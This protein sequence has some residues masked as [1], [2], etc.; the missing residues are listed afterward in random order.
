MP[1]FV[2][3]HLTGPHAGKEACPVCI[4]GQRP[5]LALFLHGRDLLAMRD[6]VRRL[7]RVLREVPPRSVIGYLVLVIDRETPVDVA[8]GLLQEAFGS[9]DLEQVMLMVARH[10]TEGDLPATMRLSVDGSPTLIGYVNRTVAFA[11]PAPSVGQ[12]DGLSAELR[13]LEDLHESYPESAVRM[14]SPTEPGEPFEI[15]G[16]VRDENGRP[17]RLA[18]VIAYAT[19]AAGRYALPTS[20]PA[21]R[22]PRLRAVAITDEDGFYRFA[23]VRPGPYANGA[24]PAHV[25]LH[26]DAPVHRHRYRT[27]WFD[28][29]PKITPARRATVDEETVV[30]PL[31]RRADGTWECRLDVRL[32]GA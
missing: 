18:S 22:M 28:G 2:P 6:V 5:T 21:D 16:R 19:D 11:L 31:R 14:C 3:W 23:G 8:S 24:E 26:F 7:E 30:V 17:L 29:D 25:H 10:H 15:H 4:Y 32:E 1:S 27:V 13:R 20:E 9:L 12:M